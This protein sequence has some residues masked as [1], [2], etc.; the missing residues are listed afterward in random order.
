V[1]VEPNLPGQKMRTAWAFGGYSPQVRRHQLIR[2]TAIKERF[3]SSSC[4]SI[5][6]VFVMTVGG[7]AKG[8]L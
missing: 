8:N 2:D 7:F 5:R 6:K 3:A 4:D 1:E